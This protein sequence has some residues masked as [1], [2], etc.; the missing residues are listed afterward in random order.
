MHSTFTLLV[1]VFHVYVCSP[2]LPIPFTCLTYA[3][4][5]CSQCG[6]WRRGDWQFFFYF[7]M[8]DYKCYKRHQPLTWR[9]WEVNTDCHDIVCELHSSFEMAKQIHRRCVLPTISITLFLLLHHPA[10]NQDARERER[11][12]ERDRRRGRNGPVRPTHLIFFFAS[13]LWRPPPP[14]TVVF[15]AWDLPYFCCCPPAR[16]R[17]CHLPLGRRRRRFVHARVG[18]WVGGWLWTGGEGGGAVAKCNCCC[19]CCC[20]SCIQWKKG[21]F[22]LQKN[23][24]LGR[25]LKTMFYSTCFVTKKS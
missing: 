12:R 25:D 10:F 14:T 21:L 9:A 24:E 18:G 2:S 20:S 13:S 15:A 22:T 23:C 3:L 17:G 16:L 4:L 8:W 5:P 11:E 6:M 1:Q 7:A 19:C